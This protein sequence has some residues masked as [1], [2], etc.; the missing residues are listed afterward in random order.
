VDRHAKAATRTDATRNNTFFVSMAGA[1]VKMNKKLSYC[2][3]SARCGWCWF[4]CGRHWR[5]LKVIHWCANRRA[6]YDF[7]L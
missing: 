4:W 2:R 7:L 1:Q 5:S 6:I 3:D